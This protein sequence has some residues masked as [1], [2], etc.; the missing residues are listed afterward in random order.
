MA[1]GTWVHGSPDP[2]GSHGGPCLP[3]LSE[4]ESGLAKVSA[5][6]TDVDI[7]VIFNPDADGKC[8]LV[9]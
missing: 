3:D 7:W 8:V 9:L 4:P 6:L 2:N 5:V 1:T